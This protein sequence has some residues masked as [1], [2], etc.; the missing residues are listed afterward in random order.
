M[1]TEEY[2]AYRHSSR[3]QASVGTDLD[4]AFLSLGISLGMGASQGELDG[5]GL[6]KPRIWHAGLKLLDWMG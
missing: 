1:T 5:F 2:L 4:A 6:Q 3:V